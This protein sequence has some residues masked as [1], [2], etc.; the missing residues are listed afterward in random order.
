MHAPGTI[1]LR[2]HH[3]MSV[4]FVR[5]SA[6]RAVKCRTNRHCHSHRL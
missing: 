3:S 2:A 5:C 6:G 4:D 1:L